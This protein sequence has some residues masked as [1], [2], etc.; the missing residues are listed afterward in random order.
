MPEE[1]VEKKESKISKM[2]SEMSTFC[3]NSDDGTVM[4]RTGIS[5]LKITGFYIL[6]YSCLACFFGICLHVAL[7]TIPEDRPKLVGRSNRPTVSPARKI[8]RELDF[9]KD[10]TKYKEG[11][12]AFIDEYDGINNN[13]T[14]NG[15]MK[16][17]KINET[18]S[19]RFAPCYVN[20]ANYV[21][22]D[23]ACFFMTINR[24]FDWVPENKAHITC[25]W[26]VGLGGTGS[27]NP[28]FDRTIIKPKEDL[29]S[30]Y[31]WTSKAYNG[32][33]P[34][35]AVQVTRNGQGNSSE[36]AKGSEEEAFLKCTIVNETG[37]SFDN[38]APYIFTIIYNLAE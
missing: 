25:A 18:P 4:G 11:V 12:A 13:A 7:M 36:T 19:S 35:W 6:F 37:A 23:K 28:G 22:G 30:Y 24:R 2:A 14:A 31:P 16:V 17:M 21:K 10:L 9:S 15:S 3:Y 27:L 32:E 38:Y 1:V 8:F 29:P 33:Q 34:V 5:W 20:D 26:D